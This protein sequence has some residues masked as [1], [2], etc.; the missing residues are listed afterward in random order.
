[1]FWKKKE[2]PSHG[3]TIT[4][5]QGVAAN[6]LSIQALINVLVNKNVCTRQEIMDELKVITRPVQNDGTKG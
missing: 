5:Q 6:A 2:I 4:V 1:M 3:K